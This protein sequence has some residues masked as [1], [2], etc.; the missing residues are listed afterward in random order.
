MNKPTNGYYVLIRQFA[1]DSIEKILGPCASIE[2]AD[3]V[4]RGVNINLAHH[5]F[6]TESAW[7]G[8]DVEPPEDI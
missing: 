8:P 4:E 6:Y 1:D 2:R 3:K 5:L 7:F